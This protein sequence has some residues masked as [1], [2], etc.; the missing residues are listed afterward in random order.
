MGVLLPTAACA[1]ADRQSAGGPIVVATWDNREAAAAA[2]AVLR[3][4]GYALDA[5]EAAARVPEADPEDHSVGL[6]GHPDRDGH[7]TL[8]A[9]VMDEHHRCGSVGALE[10]FL[11]PVTVARRV[12]ELTPHVMLVGEGAR[13]FALAQGLEQ[14]EL[15]TP[16]AEANWHKWMET[17]DYAPAINSER[18][19]RPR[20]QADDHDTIGVLALDADGRL[21]GA[22][23][24]SGLAYKMR[25]RVGDSPI[26]GAGLFVDAEAGAA[27]ATGHGEEVMRVAGASAAV[28]AM[29]YGQSAQDAARAVVE[30]IGRV[31]PSDPEAIQIGVLALG[32][33]GTVGA[34]GL[35]PGFVYVVTRP[36]AAPAPGAAGV[37]TERIPVEGGVTFLIEAPSVFS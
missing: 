8:D 21:C 34:M 3:S 6:G 11:H 7:V 19:D 20:G 24:T 35:Q 4:G 5:A 30:R 23:T 17:A 1:T 37:V 25:G 27:V 9:C 29:R 15:L 22:C 32:P 14:A 26:L 13:E 18:R 33:D 2:W 31:T 28:E 16:E 10:G 36:G 12:M